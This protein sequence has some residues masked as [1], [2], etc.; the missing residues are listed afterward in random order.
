MKECTL[1]FQIG[2]AHRMGNWCATYLREGRVHCFGCSM[3]IQSN[4]DVHHCPTCEVQ[5]CPRC[6]CYP[7]P[8]QGSPGW[9]PNVGYGASDYEV[10]SDGNESVLLYACCAYE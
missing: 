6:S 7:L 5:L 2:K 10:F 8:P 3:I 9:T 4:S 1:S